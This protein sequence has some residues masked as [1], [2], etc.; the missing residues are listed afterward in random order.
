ML[1]SDLPLC[2]RFVAAVTLAES[3]PYFSVSFRLYFNI[4][5]PLFLLIDFLLSAVSR[6]SFFPL[7]LS[8]GF[9]FSLLVIR[10]R[11]N[12]S[13]VLV[14]VS[15][16]IASIFLVYWLFLSVESPSVSHISSYFVLVLVHR[17]TAPPPSSKRD[18]VLNLS[19]VSKNPFII[20]LTDILSLHI[21]PYLFVS[22]IGCYS[23]FFLSTGIL[24]YCL[25][26][27]LSDFSEIP[28]LAY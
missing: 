1:D 15:F 11:G 8:W 7:F 24:R 9:Y 3:A 18:N 25:Y 13:G 23:P 12:P 17:S 26:V 14:F 5:A 22:F 21:F 28:F 4:A 27:F 19:T 16:F 20:F 6:S 10:E 2:F